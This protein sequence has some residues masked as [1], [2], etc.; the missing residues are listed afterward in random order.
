MG[1]GNVP[2]AHLT[3]GDDVVSVP[4]PSERVRTLRS[5]SCSLC[6]WILERIVRVDKILVTPGG[7]RIGVLVLLLDRRRVGWNGTWWVVGGW[8]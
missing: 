1:V 7:V 5:L 6:V 4:R 8:E 3:I 2:W